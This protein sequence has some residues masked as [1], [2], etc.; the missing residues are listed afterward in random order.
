M[1]RTKQVSDSVVVAI[2]PVTAYDRVSDVTQIRRWSP[3]NTGAVLAEP[4]APARVGLRFVGTNVRRGVR[5]STGCE[6][7]AADRGARFAFEVRRYGL[8][9]PV[10][11]VAIATWEYRFEAVPGGTR[12]TEIWTD[13]RRCWPDLPTLWFDRLVT[14]R[15]GFAEFQRGNIRQTLDRLKA[16]LESAA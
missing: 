2:E 3:E 7:T 14:G 5:W 6:I 15:P 9:K 12:I 11:P 13:D 10:L 16:D 1:P 8:R 4:G